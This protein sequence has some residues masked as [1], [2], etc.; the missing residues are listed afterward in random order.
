MDKKLILSLN[1]PRCL[2]ILL[3]RYFVYY[4]ESTY[5]IHITTLI[6]FALIVEA[7]D[8]YDRAIVLSSEKPIVHPKK[9]R[10]GW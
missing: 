10:P 8:L 3:L 4:S 9:F 7:Q 2:W 5:G 1:S 6:L